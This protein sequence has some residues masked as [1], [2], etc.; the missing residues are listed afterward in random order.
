MAIA[1]M[2]SNLTII[3]PS[4]H[5]NASNASEFQRQLTTA[6]ASQQYSILVDMKRVESL[7]SAGLMALISG[8]SLAQSLKRRFSLCGVA[9]SIRMIFELTQLDGAFEIFESRDAFAATNKRNTSPTDS[10][11]VTLP[12]TSARAAQ[13]VKAV[14]L[15]A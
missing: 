1:I 12:G 15:I 5:I 9:P 14:S 4:G 13:S 10:V 8:L 2:D 7:D 3:Q 6:V 11:A